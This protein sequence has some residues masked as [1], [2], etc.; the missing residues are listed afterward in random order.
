M[1]VSSSPRERDITENVTRWSSVQE[2]M[3]W[4]EVQINSIFVDECAHCVPTDSN[5]Q[6]ND[7]TSSAGAHQTVLGLAGKVVLTNPP[8]HRPPK[9][10]GCDPADRFGPARRPSGLGGLSAVSFYGGADPVFLPRTETVTARENASAGPRIRHRR[11]ER[12]PRPES[13]QDLCQ[14]KSS[15]PAAPNAPQVTSSCSKLSARQ[16]VSSGDP[17]SFETRVSESETPAV[18]LYCSAVA[19]MVRCSVAAEPRWPMVASRRVPGSQNGA[20]LPKRWPSRRSQRNNHHRSPSGHRC[21]D[22]L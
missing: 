3:N 4:T 8:T 16:S 9:P 22:R 21:G 20:V 6:P 13:Q 10:I 2:K 19:H 17:L 7:K 15:K 5:S 11:P 14:R 18:D 12:T 1:N